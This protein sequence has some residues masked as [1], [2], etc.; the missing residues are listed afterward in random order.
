MLLTHD[1][2]TISWALQSTKTGF[3]R[4]SLEKLIRSGS[5]T[6]NSLKRAIQGP[7]DNEGLLQRWPRPKALPQWE[8]L[9]N[10]EVREVDML[11]LRAKV[12][13]K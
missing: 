10:E 2:M 8:G 12:R 5:G 1:L 9:Q 4:D 7:E 3:E 11:N 13:Q 6:G